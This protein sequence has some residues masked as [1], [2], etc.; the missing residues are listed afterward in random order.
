[1]Y[2][3]TMADVLAHSRPLIVDDKL[4]GLVPFLPLN[5]PPAAQK[6]TATP[7]PAAASGTSQGGGIN[8]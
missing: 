5:V 6:P 2:L 7:A 4:K 8:Q 1:M 3:D